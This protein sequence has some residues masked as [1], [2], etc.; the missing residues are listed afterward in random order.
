MTL[1]WEYK[2][3]RV[4][5]RASIVRQPIRPPEPEPEEG[6]WYKKGLKQLL[7]PFVKR[8]H[9]RLTNWVITIVAL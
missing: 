2:S 6:E 4:P 3:A 5:P 8:V 9:L 1:W 7:H